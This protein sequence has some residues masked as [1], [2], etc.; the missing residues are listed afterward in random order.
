[1]LA[2]PV[3]SGSDL[4]VADRDGDGLTDVYAYRPRTS[5][6]VFHIDLPADGGATG[7]VSS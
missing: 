4:V 5:L 7:R 2:I 1:M 3:T 6:W